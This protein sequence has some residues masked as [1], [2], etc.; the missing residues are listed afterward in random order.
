MTSDLRELYQEC[1]LDHG[2]NP[3]NCHCL[4]D[5]NLIKE[6][7]NPLCGDHLTLYLKTDQKKIVDASFK[8]SG[9]AISIASASLMTET[10]K[11]K[12]V[13]DAKKIFHAFHLLVTSGQ[14]Q[15]MQLLGKLAVLKGVYEF[16]ARVKCATLA[17]HTMMEVITT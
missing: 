12:T 4:S 3:R 6:G 14:E 15:E 1:I 5:A 2:K 17:W 13:I 11:G 16:P 9:C 7:F 10:L 8:G